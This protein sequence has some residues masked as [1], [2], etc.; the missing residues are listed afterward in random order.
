MGANDVQVGGR[1]Y[2]GEIQHWDLIERY[3]IGYLEGC[4]TK[5]VQRWRKKNGAQDLQKAIH[6]VDKLLELYDEGCRI[7][8]GIVPINVLQDFA[9]VHELN[10]HEMGA[11][12]S[13]CA[14]TCRANLESARNDIAQL[15]LT[16]GD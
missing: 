5:Y 15:L 1:H 10:V 6:Y 11:I 13:L 16:A 4:A 8:R 12:V 3:G 14:W 7:P 2:A 9:R